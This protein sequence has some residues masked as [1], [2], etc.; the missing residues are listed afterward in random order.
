MEKTVDRLCKKYGFV[1]R[2]LYTY[3]RLRLFAEPK[4]L[5]INSRAW[6]LRNSER[7]NWKDLFGVIGS[8]GKLAF[9]SRRWMNRAVFGSQGPSDPRLF[10]VV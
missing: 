7:A 2:I 8:S 5:I 9:G 1:H 3:L 6:V 10:G 4:Y